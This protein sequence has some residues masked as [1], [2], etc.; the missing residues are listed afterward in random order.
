MH[1]TNIS[2]ARKGVAVGVTSSIAWGIN[3]VIIGV[4]L[5]KAPF[6]DTKEAIVLAPFVSSFTHDLFSSLWMILLMAVKGKIIEVLKYMKTRNGLII[7]L[8]A[9]FGGPVGMTCYLLGIN[10]IG[11]TYTASISSLFPGIGALLAFIFLKERIGPRTWLGIVLSITGVIILSY[12]PSA[13]SSNHHFLLGVLLALGSAIGW[14]LEGVICAWGMK[15]DDADPEIAVVIRQT[16]SALAYA[17]I[18]IPIIHGYSLTFQVIT[19]GAVWLFLI[20][21]FLGAANYVLYY[22]AIHL[23]G[24]A[25]GTA[26]NNTYAAWAIAISVVVFNT[27]VSF[28]LIIG[29]VIVIVGSFFVSGNLKELVHISG[30]FDN[31]NLE[32][33]KISG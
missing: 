18:V 16:A 4:I 13:G 11:A 30:D 8:A 12:M 21:A 9:L 29:T 32:E 23:I 10:Y 3:T 31:K 20:A 1:A 26:L 14:G 25:R 24:A 19:S 6:I 15:D 22:R 28:Q 2:E 27:P 17:I 5:S 7:S 33:S